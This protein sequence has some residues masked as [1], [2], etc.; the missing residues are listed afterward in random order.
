LERV[1]EFEGR[2]GGERRKG[3][4]E[5]GKRRKT[6]LEFGDDFSASTA[7]DESDVAEAG[8]SLFVEGVEAL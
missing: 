2:K 5:R 8:E 3:G 4:R 6:H 7:V 1:C